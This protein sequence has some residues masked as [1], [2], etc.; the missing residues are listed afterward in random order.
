MYSQNLQ[1]EFGQYIF[2]ALRILISKLLL[3][4]GYLLHLIP[5][6]RQFFLDYLQILRLRLQL[7]QYLWDIR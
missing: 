5:Q 2:I 3:G 6:N 7:Y 4:F 1:L